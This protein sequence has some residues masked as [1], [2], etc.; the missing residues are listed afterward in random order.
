MRLLTK[1]RPLRRAQFWAITRPHAALLAWEE[2]LFEAFRKHCI[3][4]WGGVPGCADLTAKPDPDPDP[5]RNPKPNSQHNPN[6]NPYPNP[7][8]NTQPEMQHKPVFGCQLGGAAWC[9]TLLE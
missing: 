2:P 4:T 1:Q 6:P 5:D 3:S 8:L 7:K 9:R